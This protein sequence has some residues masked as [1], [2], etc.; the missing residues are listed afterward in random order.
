MSSR[1]RVLVVEDEI[2]IQELLRYSLEQAPFEVV[3]VSSAEQALSEI[4]SELPS[5]VLLD[6]MLPGMSGINLVRHLRS[7]ERTRE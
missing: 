6:L 1:P 2:A 5:L 4:R 7:Q 3:V